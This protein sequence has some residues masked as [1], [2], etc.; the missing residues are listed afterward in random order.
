MLLQNNV[1]QAVNYIRIGLK[2]IQGWGNVWIGHDRIYSILR[3]FSL[4]YGWIRM[5]IVKSYSKKR[6]KLE[7]TD[8]AKRWWTKVWNPQT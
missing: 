5:L 8:Y 6:N 3:L 4:I 2:I 7:N 1:S